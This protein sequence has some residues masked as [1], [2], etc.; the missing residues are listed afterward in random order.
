MKNLQISRLLVFVFLATTM[1]GCELVGDIF[2]A[3]V[4]MGVIVV[5]LVIV[6]IFW[7][8]RKLMG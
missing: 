1:T 4:W 5:V 6:L 8:F 7:I 3:G 2:E